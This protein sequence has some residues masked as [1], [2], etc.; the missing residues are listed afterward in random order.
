MS[1]LSNIRSLF[2][3][4]DKNPDAIPNVNS[5][6]ELHELAKK[7]LYGDGL[8]QNLSL[9][10]MYLEF[11]AQKGH[12]ESIRTLGVCYSEGLGVEQSFEKAF[13]LYQKAAASGLVDA[14]FDLGVCYRRGEGVEMDLEKAKECYQKAID[15]G[16]DNALVNMGVI[17]E[18]GQTWRWPSNTIR[19]RLKPGTLTAN[20]ATA[21]CF[22]IGKNMRKR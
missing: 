22:T 1:I 16:N 21:C 15:A 9:A 17:Y 8:H 3:A 7:Y 5:L 20:S 14:Y 13:E 10:I 18:L 19:W 12:A 11:A 2:G 4:K 6:D